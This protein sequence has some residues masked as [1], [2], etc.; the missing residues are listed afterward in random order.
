MLA[1][2]KHRDYGFLHIPFTPST[3]KNVPHFTPAQRRQPAIRPA[4][5]S[6]TLS[7]RPHVVRDANTGLE[8]TAPTIESKGPSPVVTSTSH[9]KRLFPL[10]QLTIGDS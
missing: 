2:D 9:K 7:P 1:S 5:L 8:T 4:T 3:S 6:T 10:H